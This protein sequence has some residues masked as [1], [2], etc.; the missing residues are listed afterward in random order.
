MAKLTFLAIDLGAS[1]GRVIAGNF[2]GDTITSHEVHRF[3]NEPVTLY[4]SDTAS[5]HWDVLRLW[6]DIGKGLQAYSGEVAGISV[7]TWGVDY[8][9]LDQ[10]GKLLAN[11]HHYRDNRNDGMLERTFATVSREEIYG[12]TGIQ[13]MQI[14]TL[15]QLHGMVLREEAVLGHAQH[16]L[17]MPDLFHYWLSGAMSL[18]YTDA[19]TTQMLDARSRS[20]ALPLLEKLHLPT[21]LLPDVTD[22]ASII[23]HLQPRLASDIN[24]NACPIIAS[25]GH[26]TAAAVAAIPHLDESSVYISSGTWSLMGIE[27]AEPVLSEAARHANMTNEG[28]V[29]G[30]IRLLKNLAGMW[31]LQECQRHWQQA[32]ETYSWQALLEQAQHATPF[33]SLVRL[34]AETFLNPP[35]MPLALREAC[36][37]SGQVVPESVGALTRCC[38]ESLALEYKQ[39]LREL[40]N[41]SGRTF[42]TIRIVG[43]GSQNTLLCQLTADACQL[44]VVAGP[45]EATALGNIMLQA[46]ATGHIHSL[47]EGRQV[48]AASARQV[49][50]EPRGDVGAWDE[51]FLKFRTLPA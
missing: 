42:D 7:D 10:N 23:G 26:D 11:P 27:T 19:S 43:G 29:F 6:A 32:G 22:S 51:A 25:A 8:A 39:V 5:V 37:Q 35:D 40:E 30:T 16:L 1:S 48:I 28:G 18:E 50:Y 47:A 46:I 17:M 24:L 38:L 49:V 44:P 45:V 2:D 31:V 15:Y 20:W 14:N 41:V 21:H 33:A 9:L 12:H 36:K 3:N 13:F 34:G 4:E